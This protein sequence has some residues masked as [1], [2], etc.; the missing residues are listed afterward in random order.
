MYLSGLGVPQDYVMAQ[1]W[2]NIAASA[3]AG[4]DDGGVARMLLSGLTEKMTPDQIAEAQRMA[5]SW[6]DRRRTGGQR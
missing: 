3:A 6:L 1:M 2:F 5:R 4:L